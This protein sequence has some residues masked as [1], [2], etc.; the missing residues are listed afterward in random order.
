LIRTYIVV[1][2]LLIPLLHYDFGEAGGIGKEL[3]V[4]TFASL[5]ETGA[6]R[7]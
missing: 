6:W 7:L 3:G 1:D 5:G 4:E 2:I